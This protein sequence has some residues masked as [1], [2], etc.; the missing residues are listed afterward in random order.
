MKSPFLLAI[1]II[2]II[3]CIQLKAEI[4]T[5]RQVDLEQI[6]NQTEWKNNVRITNFY[7]DDKPVFFALWEF[8]EN[9]AFKNYSRMFY[10]YND[11]NM[12]TKQIVQGWTG[13]EWVN[14][15]MVTYEYNDANKRTLYLLQLFEDGEWNNYS[16][17]LY[18][19][20]ENQILSS[21]YL[22]AWKENAWVTNYLDSFQVNSY[23]KPVEKVSY[24]MTDGM[25]K[26]FRYTY[27]YS[28][29]SLLINEIYYKWEESKW[30]NQSMIDYYYTELKKISITEQ[31]MWIGGNWRNNNR[32]EYV[33]D[34]QAREI[35]KIESTWI[36][37]WTN[38]RQDMTIYANDRIVEYLT[39]VWFNDEWGN[40]ER[41]LVEYFSS[42]NSSEILNRYS[43][44]LSPKPATDFIELSLKLEQPNHVRI[45]LIN[46]N[47]S[48]AG[49]LF[50]G[51]LS[52]G[53]NEIRFNLSGYPSGS[54]FVIFNLNGIAAADKI[55][56]IK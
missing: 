36:E 50:D 54:Y 2:L 10:E 39:Q 11:A 43:I 51:L 48:F 28:D 5:L 35:N 7:F 38:R 27:N 52:E 55:T 49:I 17:N 4:D 41:T 40:Y 22:E 16:R 1:L 42:V 13:T 14:G 15:R 47:G 20:D 31:K 18:Y 46:S 23:G 12:L 21:I 32:M 29:D 3:P 8:W 9:G 33:Y 44:N 34:E 56:I 6:W 30:E 24:K 25:Q 45:E 37:M 19:Y 53:T 26:D